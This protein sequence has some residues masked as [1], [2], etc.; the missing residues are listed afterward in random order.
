MTPGYDD[1]I[2]SFANYGIRFAYPDVWNLEEESDGPDKLIT[3]S[4]SDTCFWMTRIMPSCPA[5]QDVVESCLQGFEEY[6]DLEQ[7]TPAARLAGMPATARDLTFFCF[8]M[9]TYAGLRC[10]RIT[11]FSV[12]VWWQAVQSDWDE[13]GPQLARVT[14]SFEID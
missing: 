1:S 6:D 3:I 2:V 10:V 8:D 9:P 14:A 12:L 11:D 4:S 7:T 5:P 13:L